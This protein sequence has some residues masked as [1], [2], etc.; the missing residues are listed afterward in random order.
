MRRLLFV[1]VLSLLCFACSESEKT[2]ALCGAVVCKAGELCVDGVCSAEGLARKCGA[3]LCEGSELCLSGVCTKRESDVKHGDACEPNKFL[4]FCQDENH[5]V[6]CSTTN[7]EVVIG[8]CNPGSLC[9]M[10]AQ[11]NY[12]ACTKPDAICKTAGQEF[13][14]CNLPSYVGGVAYMTY[15]VCEYGMDDKL[16]PFYTDQKDSDCL[17]GCFDDYSCNKLSETCD[18]N[19]YQDKCDGDVYL[20]CSEGNVYRLNCAELG[21]VCNLSGDPGCTL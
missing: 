17:S 3:T 7:S 12:S 9:V 14:R 4:E 21:L 2:E 8:E 19:S 1:L 5:F 6:T 20:Y 10:Q 13:E 18:E 11:E 15:H 16:Y